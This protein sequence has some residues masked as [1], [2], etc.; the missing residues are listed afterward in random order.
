MAHLLALRAFLWP[1]TRRAA[2]MWIQKIITRWKKRPHIS[3]PFLQLWRQP[4]KRTLQL[5]LATN[6]R[7]RFCWTMEQIA[8]MIMKKWDWNEP[9]SFPAT[10]RK[11]RQVAVLRWVL[12]TA[13][14]LKTSSSRRSSESILWY[15]ADWPIQS[16]SRRRTAVTRQ[17]IL[18]Q[19]ESRKRQPRSENIHLQMTWQWILKR[20]RTITWRVVCSAKLNQFSDDNSK[21]RQKKYTYTLTQRVTR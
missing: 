17:T 16:R 15:W 13:P 1:R 19:T 20:C 7:I 2:R 5:L 10:S 6:P 8:A 12:A 18:R 11:R 14:P 9:R 21:T 3:K 4:K